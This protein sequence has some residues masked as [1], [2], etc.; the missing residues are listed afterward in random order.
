MLAM[1][2]KEKIGDRLKKRRAILGMSL[3]ELSNASGDLY[4]PSRIGNYEQ[5]IRM[6]PLEVANALA[7]PLECSA[8]YLLCY[9]ENET[10]SNMSPAQQQLLKAYMDAPAS[11]QEGVR[12]LLNMKD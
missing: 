3:T 10:I 11:L 9:D 5:G 4:S 1:N 8:T 12:R 7:I 2:L 6:L